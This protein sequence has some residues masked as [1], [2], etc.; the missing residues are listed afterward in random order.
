LPTAGIRAKRSLLAVENLVAAVDVILKSTAG[1]RR[2]II[3]ADPGALSIPEIIAA[4]R[5]GLGRPSR[6]FWAPG[7]AVK[8]GLYMVG[9]TDE[10]ERLA[11]S[12]VADPETLSRLSWRPPVETRSGLESLGASLLA[13][14]L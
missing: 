1:L 13:Q 14:R 7:F 2:P 8:A 5:K 4:I 3:V 11:R 9:Q 10:F 12:C 6:Q